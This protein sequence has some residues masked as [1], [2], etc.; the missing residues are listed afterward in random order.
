MAL[1]QWFKACFWIGFQAILTEFNQIR[2]G[3]FYRLIFLKIGGELFE[4]RLLFY[5][6]MLKRE[7]N[8]KYLVQTTLILFTVP[9]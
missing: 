7:W 1:Y 4:V 2:N 8:Y 3:R 5:A 6:R 9:I